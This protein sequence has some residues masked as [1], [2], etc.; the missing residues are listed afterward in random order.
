M[1]SIMPD[2]PNPLDDIDPLTGIP[3][4][5]ESGSATGA[6]AVA[7]ARKAPGPTGGGKVGDTDDDKIGA[8]ERAHRHK[9][10]RKA[11]SRMLAVPA[12]IIDPI[13]NEGNVDGGKV[14]GVG[15]M[16]K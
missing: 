7:A 15:G 10:G 16:G 8:V 5:Q 2:I 1:G 13:V 12:L 9:R 3:Y 14:K 11:L 4:S 6:L